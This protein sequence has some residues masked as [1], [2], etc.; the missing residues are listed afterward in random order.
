M[1][2]KNLEAEPDCEEVWCLPLGLEVLGGCPLPMPAKDALVTALEDILVAA[3]EP[4]KREMCRRSKETRPV[5]E[6]G[7]VA[8]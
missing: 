8:D 5:L 4:P 3:D 6:G 2:E 7:E 1:R